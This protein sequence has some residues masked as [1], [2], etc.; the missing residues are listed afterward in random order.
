VLFG[1]KTFL[2]D[3]EEELEDG[4]AVLSLAVIKTLLVDIM[5]N[6]ANCCPRTW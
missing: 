5:A 2:G 4:G 6:K 1:R 3:A